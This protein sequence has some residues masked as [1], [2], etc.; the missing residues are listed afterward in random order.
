LHGLIGRPSWVRPPANTDVSPRT[1]RPYLW[2]L[3]RSSGQANS[4]SSVV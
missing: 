1:P 3:N 4:Y 2:T